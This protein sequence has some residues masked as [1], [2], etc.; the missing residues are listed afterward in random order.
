[1]DAAPARAEGVELLGE[2]AASGYREPPTLIRRADGQVIKLT[3]LLYELVDSIDGRRGPEQLAAEL[4]RRVRRRAT[5]EDVR[6]LIDHKLRPLGVLRQPDGSDP[7][8]VKSNPLLVLRPRF[9]LSRERTT[10]RLTAPF[11][12][13]FKP[14]LVIPAILAFVALGAW[15]LTDKGL[16]SALHQMFYEPGMILAVWALI[17]ISA[18]FHEIGHA[19]ACRYGG[20]KPG[21]IGGGLYLVWPAFYTE[22]TDAYR[23]SRGA[24]LRVDLGG[25]YFSAL[26][27]IATAAVW[28]VTGADALLLVIAV[29]LVQMVRQ[30]APFIRADGYHVIADLTGVPDLF[31]HIKPTLLGLLP[32][33]RGRDRN[34]ALKPW[35]RAVVAGWVAITVPLLILVL[36]YIVLMFPRLAATAWDSMGL[37]WAEA[38]AYWNAGEAAGV[39][40]SAIYVVLLALPVFGIVYL[41]SYLGRRMAK[42]AWRGTRGRPRMRA[43]AVLAGAALLGLLAW[44]WW[45]S[46][47]YR[48]INADEPAPA[49]TI[50][51][52]PGTW[53]QMVDFAPAPVSAS[54]PAV[55]AGP[56]VPPASPVLVPAPQVPIAPPPLGD[57]TSAAPVR[58]ALFEPSALPDAS[59]ATAPTAPAAAPP[60]AWPFPWDPPEP[61]EPG[62]NFAMAVNTT[63]GSILWEFA[64]S[65]LLLEGGDPVLHGNEAH[66]YASCTNCVTGAVAFQVLLILGQSDQIVPL[67]AAVAA[68][69]LCDT[70]GTYAFAYQIIASIIEAPPAEVQAHLDLAFEQLASLQAN[71]QSMSA[72]EILQALEQVESDILAALEEILA[73]RPA[74]SIAQGLGG[75]SGDG[76]PD[77]GGS[78]ESGAEGGSGPDAAS[79]DPTGVDGDTGQGRPD[80]SDQQP[81]E[82]PAPT[83]QPDPAPTQETSTP[84][85]EPATTGSEEPET[86]ATSQEPDPTAEAPPTDDPSAAGETAGV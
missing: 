21:V 30:L 40:M 59:A 17:V 68:N 26:F 54:G 51:L 53:V 12:W 20:A 13:L 86:A 65:M 64:L 49:P 73:V 16:S 81:N 23:L 41:V 60:P 48:P 45:P 34:D 38:A 74:T 22:V 82:P 78:Q 28:R 32:T 6:F 46:E 37:R 69:Y 9:A 7:E 44:A 11:V 5:P 39:A 33:R 55:A 14:F 36:G 25:L 10:Q 3:P 47:K 18:F 19:A 58:P 71:A 79:Q 4:G 77:P 31:A 24:R 42:S 57:D 84:A 50:M 35:A 66:A 29:Q 76:S 83:D 52:S 15:L 67:N 1:M 61:P 8:L 80:A 62:D 72:G 63:D 2:F 85:P 75:P 43:L 56:G 27:A 70:C